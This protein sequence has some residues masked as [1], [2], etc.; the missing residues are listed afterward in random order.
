MD[1][2]NL[3]EAMYSQRSFTRFRPEP[4]PKEAIEKIIDAAIRAPNG[5]NRQPWEFIAIT[6]PEVIAKVGGV[7][8]DVWLN[9]MGHEAPPDETPAYKA[10][11]YLANH[12]PE[13]PAMILIC[14]V[15]DGT[16][17]ATS[18]S[19]DE[20]FVRGSQASSVWPAAQNLFLAARALGLGTR[21][22]TAHLRGE[23]RVKDILGIPDHVETVMLTPLGYP[24]GNF[25]PTQRKPA[26]EVTSYNRYGNR[27]I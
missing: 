26:A 19:Q 5:G 25:G 9:A 20:P 1:D 11:R 15:H 22:T 12:M 21:L 27:G 23:Q 18:S 2:M 8:K 6:D 3:F 24:R 17:P 14:A 4:V 10:A 13:V 16:A 7:Y